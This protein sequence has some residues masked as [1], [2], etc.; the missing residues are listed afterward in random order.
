[1]QT[2]QLSLFIP[3]LLIGTIDL[4]HCTPLSVALTVAVDHSLVKANSVDLFSHSFLN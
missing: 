4:Y 3:A 1:M 2:F